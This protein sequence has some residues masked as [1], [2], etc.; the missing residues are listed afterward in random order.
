MLF[1]SRDYLTIL[2]LK[3]T[4]RKQ[5]GMKEFLDGQKKVR[6]TSTMIGAPDLEEAESSGKYEGFT[7]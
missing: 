3:S 2:D 7:L 5:D 1:R 6:M 4:D